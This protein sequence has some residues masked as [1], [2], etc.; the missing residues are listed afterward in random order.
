[1]SFDRKRTSAFIVIEIILIFVLKRIMVTALAVNFLFGDEYSAVSIFDLC[2]YNTGAFNTML[3]AIPENALVIGKKSEIVNIREN[4]V[5]LCSIGG[6][7]VIIRVRQIL[8]E[9]GKKYY[10]VKFD[11]TSSEETFQISSDAVK[12]KILWQINGSALCVDFMT[13]TFGIIIMIIIPFIAIIAAFA[14]LILNIR[15]ILCLV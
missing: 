3:P 1:M 10:I 9:E 15:R 5:I 7:D 6:R 2:F 13:S 14:A 4:S 12:A 11:M 8:E